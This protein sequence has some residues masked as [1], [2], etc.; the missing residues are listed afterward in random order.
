MAAN[1][2]ETP[3]SPRTAARMTQRPG[4]LIRRVHQLHAA[5]WASEVS[6]EVTPTQFAVLS[7]VVE[8]PHGDQAMVSR[9][10]SL[11]SSTAGSVIYRLVQRGWIQVDRDPAD[12]RRNL[13]SL[14]PEGEAAHAEIAPAAAEM[15]EHL[16]GALDLAEQSTLVDLLGKIIGA[17]PGR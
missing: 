11:D 10:A 7:A 13:L 16:V 15:T 12:R 3:S 5:L 9:E 1:L 2:A 14:T 4:H 6:K 17:H 8:N